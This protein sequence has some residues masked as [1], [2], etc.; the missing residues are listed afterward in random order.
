MGKTL[1]KD[2]H[3]DQLYSIAWGYLISCKFFYKTIVYFSL[4][5]S[6]W[7]IAF[8][9]VQSNLSYFLLTSNLHWNSFML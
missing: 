8:A 6:G 9:S 2:L 5:D 7:Y 3:G 1:W 4:S